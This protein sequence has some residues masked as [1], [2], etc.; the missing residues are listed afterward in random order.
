MKC[1]DCGEDITMAGSPVCL[2]CHPDFD[3][4]MKPEDALC[5]ECFT[6]RHGDHK[7]PEA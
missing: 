6:V 1:H 4:P 5:D 3:K 7:R 2:V